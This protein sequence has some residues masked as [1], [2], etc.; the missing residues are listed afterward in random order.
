MFHEQVLK[1]LASLRV[2]GRL[3]FSPGEFLARLVDNLKP[4]VRRL[5]RAGH[6]ELAEGHYSAA[7]ET[8]SKLLSLQPRHIM[9]RALLAKAYE[10]MRMYAESTN[11]YDRISDYDYERYTRNLLLYDHIE[12]V[13]RADKSVYAEGVRMLRKAVRH[14]MRT[15]K[16]NVLVR[17]IAALKEPFTPAPGDVKHRAQEAA[18]S[19]QA[20]LSHT[21]GD[22]LTEEERRKFAAL[23]QI[24]EQDLAAIDWDSLLDHL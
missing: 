19:L 16:R 17:I 18:S 22:F 10:A 24:T 13:R 7:A 6:D 8:L 11:E 1:D 15:G 2:R 3:F 4:S 14:M 5:Y 9:A 20:Q 23:P 21:Q 12:M